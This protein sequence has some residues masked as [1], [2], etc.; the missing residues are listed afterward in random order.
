MIT[1]SNLKNYILLMISVLFLMSSMYIIIFN[2]KLTIAQACIFSYLF[3]LFV[4]LFLILNKTIRIIPISTFILLYMVIQAFGIPLAML[5][6]EKTAT[7]YLFREKLFYGNFLGEYISLSIAAISSILLSLLLFKKNKNIAN[8]EFENNGSLNEVGNKNFYYVIGVTL[9]VVFGL[10]MSFNFLTG[11]MPISYSEYKLWQENRTQNYLQFGFWFGCLFAIS[12]CRKKQ[13]PF[14][15]LIFIIPSVILIMTGNRNDVLYPLIIS[16]G[17]YI[18]RF[19]RIP[20]IPLLLVTIFITVISPVIS[21]TRTQ[22]VELSVNESL[23]E[24]IASSL[25]EFGS[26]LTPISHVFQWIDNGENYAYG[27]TYIYGSLVGIFSPFFSSLSLWFSSSRF[28]ISERLPALGFSMS[29]EILF[30]FSIWGVVIIYLILGVYWIKKESQNL[31]T[32]QLVRYSFVC[33]SLLVLVRNSFSTYITV[34]IMFLI[35]YFLEKLA[36]EILIR[37]NK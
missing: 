25:N 3:L 33:F 9:I 7:E 8:N 24:L 14:L 1:V 18:Y 6:D 10:Y 12:S 21:S 11:A 30:N 19:R 22:G 28:N 29:G 37:R 34:I 20:V 2:I 27:S 23:K 17:V 15:L 31:D 35:L 4:C 32:D 16:L 36:R 13:V 5:I 26:Q